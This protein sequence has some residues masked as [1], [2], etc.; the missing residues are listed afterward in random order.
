MPTEGKIQAA[1][2]LVELWDGLVFD[3]KAL[4]VMVAVTIG[5]WQWA[6]MVGMV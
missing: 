2:G 1:L 3:A 5:N 6:M 4:G